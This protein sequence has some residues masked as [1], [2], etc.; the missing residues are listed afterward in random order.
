MSELYSID[1]SKIITVEDL[2]LIIKAMDLKFT[3]ENKNF[4]EI[5]HLLTRVS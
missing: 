1:T 5:K 4:E 2:F 3:E